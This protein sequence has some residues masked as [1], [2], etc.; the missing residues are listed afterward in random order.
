MAAAADQKKSGHR[1]MQVFLVQRHHLALYKTQE[2][3][4]HALYPAGLQMAISIAIL[5]A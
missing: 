2:V 3:E 4:N 5:N 1:R